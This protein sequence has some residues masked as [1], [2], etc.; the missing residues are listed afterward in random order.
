M[1]MK[2]AAMPRIPPR[3]NQSPGELQYLNK[4]ARTRTGAM[5]TRAATAGRQAQ[6]IALPKNNQEHTIYQTLGAD[7]D[8]LEIKSEPAT[9]KYVAEAMRH[10]V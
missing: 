4:Q 6:K 9:V 3:N 10:S 8:R 5:L 2:K 1:M 7:S